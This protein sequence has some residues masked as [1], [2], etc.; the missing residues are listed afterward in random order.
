MVDGIK[1]IGWAAVLYNA[2]GVAIEWRKGRLSEGHLTSIVAELS[3]MLE[4]IYWIT[5]MASWMPDNT[6]FT[7]FSDSMWAIGVANGDEYSTK[8]HLEPYCKEIQ[9]LRNALYREGRLRVTHLPGAAN[10]DADRLSR[11][12]LAG[13][14][15]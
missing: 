15:S 6:R 2:D 10:L 4:A 9:M 8:E 3:A 11:E 1:R 13:D 7:L 12:A 14:L 5:D